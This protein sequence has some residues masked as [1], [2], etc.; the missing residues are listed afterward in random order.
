MSTTIT[1]IGTI[2][3]GYIYD[4][5][6]RR[7]A[8]GTQ[9]SL[10]CNPST[11]TMTN[12][13]VLGQDGQTLTETDGSGNWVHTDVSAGA[14]MVTYTP[15]GLNFQFA[16]WLGTRRVQTDYA[17][18]N[19]V[20]FQSLPFGE[21]I[22]SLSGDTT[23]KHFTGKEH[24]TESGNDYFDARYYASSMGRFM[25]PD[26]SAKVEPV[27]YSKLDNPQSLNLYSYVY[28]NPLSNA[29]PEGH[30]PD[31]HKTGCVDH[32]I[33][34]QDGSEM[35]S[36]AQKQSRDVTSEEGKQILAN[37]EGMEGTPYALGGNSKSAIDCIHMV[38]AALNKAGIEARADK[39]A[40]DFEKDVK[41]RPLG[42]DEQARTG[43]IVVWRNKTGGHGH[44][45]VYDANPSK[46]GYNIYS[47]TNH[48]VMHGPASWFSVLGTPTYYRVEVPK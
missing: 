38:C 15:T 48:G 36:K 16:D 47:A 37:A 4:A 46:S 31:G 30:D 35:I 42:K 25:I 24:D 40:N 19:P 14:A 2:Y 8:K 39:P 29:D 26:W 44:V 33:E 13:Y 9:T 11:L 10:S 43:D 22:S 27:P 18:A 32:S 34:C 20:T 7:V 12:M 1:G 23:E 45:G 21:L 28:N 41:M 17:G 3:E 6:G 5:E